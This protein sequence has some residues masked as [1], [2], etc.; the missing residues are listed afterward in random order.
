MK[1]ADV[2][3]GKLKGAKFDAGAMHRD[4]VKR[5]LRLNDSEVAELTCALHALAEEPPEPS[6]SETRLGDKRPPL[7]AILGK[8]PSSEKD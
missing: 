2:L 4:T 6:P 8:G 3:G 7:L 1:L 5:L